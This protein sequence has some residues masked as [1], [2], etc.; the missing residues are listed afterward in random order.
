MKKFLLGLFAVLFAVP[1]VGAQVFSPIERA[2]DVS[3][4]KPEINSGVTKYENKMIA[5]GASIQGSATNNTVKVNTDLTDENDGTLPEGQY[6]HYIAGGAVYKNTAKGNTVNISKDVTIEGRAV[7]GGLARTHGPDTVDSDKWNTGSALNNTVNINSATITVAPQNADTV[8]SIW[9]T[10]PVA[11]AGGASQYFS[12]DVSGNTV[13]I[14]NGSTIN[15]AVVGG[16]SY[17]LTT[18]EEV[19]EHDITPERSNDHNTVF[20]KDSAVNGDVYGSLGG[21]NGNYN[22]VRLDNAKI[23]G[24]V[25]AAESGFSLH[26][27]SASVG[28]FNY[29][30]VE[31]LN[32]TKVGSAAAVDANNNNASHNS[33]LIQNSAVQDGELYTVK[34]VH[35][36][37]DNS[38]TISGE[39]NYNSLTLQDLTGI[40][41]NEIGGA[42]NFTGNPAGNKVEI[43]NSD[44]TVLFNGNKTFG[45]V[46]N[47]STLTDENLLG[48]KS[49]QGHIITPEI[50]LSN[51][52]IFGGATAD[53][54]SKVNTI[55]EE[56]E[57]KEV[58]KGFGSSSDNNTVRITGGTVKANVVGG[59]ASYVREVNY[60]TIT[61]DDQGRTT[62]ETCVVKNGRVTT[63]TTTTYTYADET[64]TTGTSETTV[65]NSDPAELIDEK[66]SASNNTIELTDVT[67]NGDVYGGYVDGAEL[68]QDNM[69]TQNNT[70]IL[71][72]KSQVSGKVYGGSNVYYGDT[73]HLIFRNNADGNNFVA[74]KPSSFVNFNPVW[75]IEGNYDTRLQFTQGDVHAVLTLDNSVMQDHA[76]TTIL[77]TGTVLDGYGPVHCNGS[78]NCIKYNSDISLAK[79]KLG[80]YTFALT[81][82][83]DGDVVNWTLSGQKESTNLEVYGQL[84]LVGLALT[85]EGQEMLGSAVTDA[86]KNENDSNSFLNGAYHHT[87]YKTGSGF[88]LDSGIVQAGAW[89]KFTSDWLGGFFVKYAHGSYETFPIDVNGDADVYGGGLLT[90]LRYSETGRLEVDAEIGYMDMEFKSPELTSTFKSKGMYYGF[91]AGFVETLV[92]DL[93]LF[94]NFRYL[95][96]NKDDITDNLG[97]KINFDTMQSMALRFGAEYLFSGLDLYGLKPAIGAMGI[98]EMDGEA[99]VH[100]EDLTSSD[101]SLKGMSG[102]AQLSLVYNNKDTFLPLRTALT[103]YGLAGKRE[104][105]GGEINI[106]FSF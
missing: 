94:A 39:T 12:G 57:P 41:V 22:T 95:R 77:K 46:M 53:Y 27:G 9:G 28:T 85:M 106:A 71:A 21:V 26:D 25:I 32:G 100:A 76:P 87:R 19:D 51:G 70:V 31:L 72:G 59:F 88:D 40:T 18:Q 97:Q 47:L 29:N 78:D 62:E 17:V 36:L 65:E 86:W 73:N 2:G 64:D 79:D 13:N 55:P 81:P 89:K 20:I 75:S 3:G 102:R 5:G 44:I 23:D 7:A 24:K 82:E 4:E 101:A 105:V 52:F 99:T 30:R 10:N 15:G 14:T 34:M 91:G 50:D 33:M 63:T 6:N 98:Y 96:K 67:L 49:I 90:S 104:G 35:G 103:V 42:L 58:I 68:K 8:F 45:G 37:K 48:T 69:L 56:E 80:I 54:T 66:F 84:P 1:S 43:L 83:I 11:V 93:D 16:L 60:S 38:D 61:K 74:Y 92:E